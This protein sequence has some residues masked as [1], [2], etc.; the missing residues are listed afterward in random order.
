MDCG[1]YGH[2]HKNGFS[3]YTKS[4]IEHKISHPTAHRAT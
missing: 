4:C 3:L 2:Q 1:H